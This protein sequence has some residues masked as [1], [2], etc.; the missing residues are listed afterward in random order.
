MTGILIADF[1]LVENEV[2]AHDDG[3]GL[4][5]CGGRLSVRHVGQTLPGRKSRLS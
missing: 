1:Y 2:D 3:S 4:P 5:S